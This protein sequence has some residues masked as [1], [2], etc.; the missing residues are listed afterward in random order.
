MRERVSKVKCE[1]EMFIF[2]G[3]VKGVR[4]MDVMQNDRIA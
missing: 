1:K 2:P 3:G 4:G